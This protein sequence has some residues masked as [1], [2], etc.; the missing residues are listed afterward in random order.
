MVRK[1]IVHGLGAAM[2][3][4]ALAGCAAQD[5]HRSTGQYADDVTTTARVREALLKTP[6]LRS[7]TIQVETYQGVVQLSGFADNEDSAASAVG[8][9]RGVAGVKEIRNN[10]QVRNPQ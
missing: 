10:I 6:N 3:A 2:L 7:N 8:A 9:A 4:L 1:S 5:G